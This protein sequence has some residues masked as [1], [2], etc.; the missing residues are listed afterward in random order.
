MRLALGSVE[1]GDEGLRPDTRTS[2]S[3]GDTTFGGSES[4]LYAVME[5]LEYVYGISG[6]SIASGPA[7]TKESVYFASPSARPFVEYEYNRMRSVL[8]D[9]RNLFYR[10]NLFLH[11]RASFFS[12]DVNGPIYPAPSPASLPVHIRDTPVAVMRKIIR[13]LV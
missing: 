3:R 5:E 11:S 4:T 6:F 2:R 8:Y 13:R 12:D 1:R 7:N 9:H 10:W